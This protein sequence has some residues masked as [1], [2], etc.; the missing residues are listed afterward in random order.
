MMKEADI[1]GDSPISYEDFAA[2]IT[3]AAYEGQNKIWSCILVFR[4]VKTWSRG[5]KTD[6]KSC[7]IEQSYTTKWN[8]VVKNNKLSHKPSMLG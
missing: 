7:L 8:E 6:I 1:D 3:F 2:S 4:V 5:D